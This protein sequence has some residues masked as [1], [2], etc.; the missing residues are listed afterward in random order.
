[1]KV[2]FR[3]HDHIIFCNK[4]KRLDKDCK[5]YQDWHTTAKRNA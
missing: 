4:I 5:Y 1:M 2:H 3:Y